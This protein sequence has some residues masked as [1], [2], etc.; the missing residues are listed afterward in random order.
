MWRN[1][2]VAQRFKKMKDTGEG[3]EQFPIQDG[4]KYFDTSILK[5][6]KDALPKPAD[7]I[8]NDKGERI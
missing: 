2:D 7:V 3:A 6:P 8:E 1:N 4:K 5:P